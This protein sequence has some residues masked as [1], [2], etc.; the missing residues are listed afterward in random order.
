VL[1]G[2]QVPSEGGRRHDVDLESQRLDGG[3]VVDQD[4][5]AARR[6]HGRR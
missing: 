1:R 3:R 5:D 6:E 2:D 4:V